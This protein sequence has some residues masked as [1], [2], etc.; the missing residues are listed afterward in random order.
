MCR[1]VIVD[2]F[3]LYI[4]ITTILIIILYVILAIHI[5]VSQSFIIVSGIV[6]IYNYW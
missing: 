6:I 3:V 2:V 5:K 4:L 1:L